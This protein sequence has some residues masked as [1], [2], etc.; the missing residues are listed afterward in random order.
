MLEG[1][2]VFGGSLREGS[3]R[4][5]EGVSAE[6]IHT[7]GPTFL[8]KT[9]ICYNSLKSLANHISLYSTVRADAKFM[10]LLAYLDYLIII[11]PMFS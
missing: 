1:R 3:F 9:F 8:A 10:P 4:V 2:A 5:D 6:A 7:K 11:D